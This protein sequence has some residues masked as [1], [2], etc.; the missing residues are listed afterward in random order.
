M[1]MA[2]SRTHTRRRP[3]SN[4]RGVITIAGDG[5]GFVQTAEGSFFIPASKTG[6]AFDGDLV[7]IVAA[8]L[9][10][11]GKQNAK[12]HAQ[13]GEK[14]TGRVVSVIQRA[15]ET[16]V[17]RYEIADPFGVVIPEDHR[18]P[19]DIFT[20]R[21]DNPQVQDGDVVRVRI[22]QFPSRNSAATGT[23]EEVLGREGQ[24]G[25][26]IETLIGR[27][28][29][30]TKFS[31]AAL[32]QA[33]FAQ[34]DEAGALA[35]GY[36]DLSDRF[37]F[38]VDPTDAR[39]FDDALSLVQLD[40]GL[41]RLGVHIADVSFYVPWGSSVDLDARRRATSVYLA[42]RVIPMLPEELS[43]DVCSL[44]PYKTRR[45]MTVDIVLDAQAQVK[46]VDIY[47]SLIVS[48]ARLSYDTAQAFIE[49]ALG[50]EGWRSVPNRPGDDVS[51]ELYRLL[52]TLHDLT[53]ALSAKRVAAGQIDF[54]QT[55]AKAVLDSEGEAVDIA[56]RRKTPATECVEEAMILANECVARKL[57]DS[58]IPAIF[59]VHE[60]PA[61]D[62]LASLVPVLQEFNLTRTVEVADI[63]AGNPHA[64]QEVLIQ[65]RGRA[66]SELISSLVLRAMQR[67]VYSP[68]CLGHYGLALDAYCHY[69]SPIRRY[70]DLVV[71][72]MLKVLLNGRDGTFQQQADN[73]A[74]LADHSSKMERIADSIARESQELKLVEYMRRFVGSVFSG[75]ISGV[76]VQGL[77][78]RLE[79]TV[80]GIV[81]IRALGAEYFSL[82]P[83]L[84]KLTGQDSGRVFRLGQHVAVVLFGAPEHARK[85]D[86]RLKEP[87]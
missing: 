25:L 52:P 35:Q 87:L 14:P 36:R 75:I 50:D 67:A 85:L 58:Q 60:P 59:R 5:Y 68:D 23:I 49:A 61:P 47:P 70:P 74:W 19:Y 20:M 38:T 13:P 6:G 29:L 42:D 17:G 31:Q 24:V 7:E 4:P 1:H 28:R 2:K 51:R 41:W 46:S 37:V 15:H 21:V 54:E 44:A 84:H 72:R 71:H 34:V 12:Q 18:I 55:E 26:D 76:S 78:V 57:R 9:N 53:Q 43:N 8:H 40:S 33:R 62:S 22:T 16:V 30:E 48:K 79:N 86:F 11:D 77:Y 65:S 63:L 56:L 82:D 83:V 45:A 27:Y 32:D 10:K 39:D 73:L 81:P 69:T 66:E 80:E 64:L 3:R